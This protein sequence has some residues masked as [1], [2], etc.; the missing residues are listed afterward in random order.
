[1]TL[2]LCYPHGVA[3]ELIPSILQS[4]IRVIDLSADFR[5]RDIP[6]WEKW[7]GQDHAAPELVAKAVY[8]LPETNRKAIKGAQLIACPGVIP[9]VFS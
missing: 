1:M 6:L 4:G 3:Q 8:G 9:P 7:Y 5:L 2:C